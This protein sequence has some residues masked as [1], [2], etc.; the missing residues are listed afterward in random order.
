MAVFIVCGVDGN[1]HR[2][3]IA[4][5]PMTEESR[6]SYGVLFQNLKDRGLSTPRLIISDAHSG[7]VSAIRESFP[8]ASWQR[9]KVHFVRNI[10][11]YVPQ[12]EKKAFAAVLKEIWLTP[13]AE[14]VR[15]RAYDVIDSYA[16]RFPKAVLRD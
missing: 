1:G 16:K 8:G 5:E 12:K 2:D 11:V 14:L 13:T 10:L 3:I 6:S 15:K 9:C 7:L 4:V